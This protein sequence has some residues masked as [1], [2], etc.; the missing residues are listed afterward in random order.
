M[1]VIYIAFNKRSCVTAKELKEKFSSEGMEARLI[2]SKKFKKKPNVLIRIGNSYKEAPEGCIE[3]NSIKSVK[4]ASNKLQMAYHLIQKEGVNFPKAYIPIEVRFWL[5]DLFGR[6]ED[7]HG[8]EIVEEEERIDLY[9]RNS[10][11]IVRKR[12][13]FLPGD[14]YAT[15][16]ISRAREFRVHVFGG[17]T[18]GVY[19]KIPVN[20]EGEEIGHENVLYCKNDNCT[21]RRIDVSDEEQRRSIKGVRPMAVLAVEALGLTFGGAD[22]I[23]STDGEIFV[24]EVNSAPSL[25]SLNI[26]RYYE[27][28]KEYIEEKRNGNQD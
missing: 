12:N 24:N 26:D 15:E 6:S 17:K 11:N 9:Y 20:D 16:P 1:D 2:N 23:I 7:S 14:L 4:L 18:I 10:H 21:F 8:F 13:R 22:V 3:V 25:N 28:I 19:E 5:D 27:K